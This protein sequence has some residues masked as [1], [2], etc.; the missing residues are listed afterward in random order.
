MS[1]DHII[2][3]KKKALHKKSK[4]SFVLCKIT[5]LK[6]KPISGVNVT[7]WLCCV[8]LEL[9]YVSANAW[10]LP[11]M[12]TGVPLWWKRVKITYNTQKPLLYSLKT[13]ARAHTHFVLMYIMF[14]FYTAIKTSIDTNFKIV[15]LKAFYAFFYRRPYCSDISGFT[16][17]LW[18]W[19]NYQIYSFINT[20]T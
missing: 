12:A 10:G 15:Y 17:L 18:I 14:I 13:L 3:L 6:K 2:H 8:F 11:V 7:W 19:I 4:I 1:F 5:K 9:K 16:S 20:D